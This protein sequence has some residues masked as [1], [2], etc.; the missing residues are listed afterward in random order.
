MTSKDAYIDIQ[1]IQ[2]DQLQNYQQHTGLTKEQ[3]KQSLGRILDK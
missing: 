3:L 2:E 1:R